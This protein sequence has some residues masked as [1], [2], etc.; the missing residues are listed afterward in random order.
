[1]DIS[2]PRMDGKE[3]TTEI[4]RREIGTGLRVPIAALTAHAM[5]G[6]YQNIYWWQVWITT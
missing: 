4:R 3:A 6:D 1:M 2:M 5:T